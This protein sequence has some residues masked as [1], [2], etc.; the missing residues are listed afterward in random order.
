MIKACVFDVG[1]V[2]ISLKGIR[3]ITELPFWPE[4]ISEQDITLW[5]NTTDITDKF[6][7]GK[8]SWKDFVIE[9]NNYFHFNIEDGLLRTAVNAMLG[10]EMEGIT[11]LLDELSRKLPLYIL[12]NTNQIH[13]D[14]I[15]KNFSIL[16]P[17]IAFAVILTGCESRE[18]AQEEE[19]KALVRRETEEVW[20]QGNLEVIDEIFAADFILHDPAVGEI[21]GI[22]GLKQYASMYLTA[23][24]DL[25]I[26]IN[27]QIAEGDKEVIRWIGTGTH[28]GELTGIPP[29]DIQVTFTGITISRI[30]DGKYVEKWINGDDL[31]ILQQL[32]VIPPM[33]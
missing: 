32:G 6:E 2:L 26:T 11:E 4:E 15:E 23:F 20:N 16:I 14:Y 3:P 17:F 9:F 30:V 18:K 24:P 25:K 28:K 7:S 13:W 27:D 12:S 10:S 8:A 31:G 33:E 19:N 22:E 1:G 29:T 5:F 21:R